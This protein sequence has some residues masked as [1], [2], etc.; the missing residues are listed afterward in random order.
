[1][2]VTIGTRKGNNTL[3]VLLIVVLPCVHCN[4]ERSDK[5]RQIKQEVAQHSMALT[6]AEERVGRLKVNARKVK[7]A[8]AAAS[9]TYKKTRAELD[10]AAKS[11]GE[12]SRAHAEAAK[13]Y[14][15]AQEAWQSVTRMLLLAAASDLVG[16]T[17]CANAQLRSRFKRTMI[18]KGLNLGSVAKKEK[19]TELLHSD[20][21]V[22]EKLAKI[23]RGVQ[24]NSKL[25]Q[26]VEDEQGCGKVMAEVAWEVMKCATGT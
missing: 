18:Q 6:G 13:N 26:C 7:D 17:M 3:L 4:R 9:R 24:K 2:V 22:M 5:I 19:I 1:M 12:A 16:N 14:R 8:H 20:D 25:G 21:S 15:R 23:S 10:S 11:Y